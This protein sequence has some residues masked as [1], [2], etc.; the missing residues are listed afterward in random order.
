[1]DKQHIHISA[2]ATITTEETIK[3]LAAL[4]E[5]AQKLVL[6]FCYG[7]LANADKRP[8]GSAAAKQ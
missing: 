7:L 3:R 8:N 2:D 1:M 6:G 5:D 4:P